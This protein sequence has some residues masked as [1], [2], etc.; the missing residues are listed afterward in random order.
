M[1]VNGLV[2]PVTKE[3]EEMILNHVYYDETSKTCLRFK[4]MYHSTKNGAEAFTEITKDGYYRGQL[5]GGRRFMAH[6]V[7][8]FLNH[9]YWPNIIDHADGDGLNNIITNLNDVSESENQQNRDYNDVVGGYFEKRVGKWHSRIKVNGDVYFLGFFDTKEECRGAYANA[10]VRLHTH[11][12]NRS[13][14]RSEIERL[15]K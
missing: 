6:R 4:N 1:H 2:K 11:C 13:F 12:V 14:S 5:K 15:L 10:K 9:G 3:D 7:V 8:W